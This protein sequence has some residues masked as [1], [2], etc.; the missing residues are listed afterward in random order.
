MPFQSGQFAASRSG[1]AGHEGTSPFRARLLSTLQVELAIAIGLIP[2]AQ[3]KLALTEL[4]LC[5]PL[6][7]LE[8]RIVFHG[9]V[10]LGCRGHAIRCDG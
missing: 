3:D 6:L 10:A 9:A 2:L 7:P 4:Q 1:T 8:I 5:T